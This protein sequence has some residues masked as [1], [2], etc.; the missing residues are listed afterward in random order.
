MDE[1]GDAGDVTTTFRQG[2]GGKCKQ[3]VAAKC[4]DWCTCCSS[5]SGEEY[6]KS[7]NQEAEIKE[8]RE[9]VEWFR[10]QRGEVARPEGESG[11]EEDWGMEVEE[12]ESGESKRKLDE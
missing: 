4:G 7:K 10:K 9:Q 2:C 3:A 5:S 12:F 6:K 8:L 1:G 11:M